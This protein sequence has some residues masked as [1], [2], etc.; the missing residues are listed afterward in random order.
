[1]YVE[2][3]TLATKCAP[4]TPQFLH[5][6]GHQDQKAN[7]PLTIWEQYN[8]NCNERAKGYTRSVTQSS[9]KLG[10]PAIP[11]AQPHLQI[12]GKIV[13]RNLITALRD[14]TSV[15]PYLQY[16]KKKRQWTATDI[17]H[18]H[19]T[20]LNASLSK[21]KLED[22]R[23]L[24]LFINDK[25]PLCASKAHPHIGSP[26]CPSCQRKPETPCHF[27]ECNHR[28]WNKLFETLRHDLSDITQRFQ[29]HPC[30]FTAIWLGL[31][32]TRQNAAYPDITTEII[33][34]LILPIQIQTSLG[35]KQLYYGHVA[36]AWASAI[37]EIHPT[38]PVNGKQIL[39]QMITAIWTHTMAA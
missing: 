17:R 28:E 32:T 36:T 23:Q 31:S 24:I 9:T 25:L 10:N 35:W 26:L 34:S 20:V 8:I 18:V 13:C 21:F 37:D 1:V 38:L 15:P 33:P 30:I 39:I 14:A 6:K 4:L 29:L 22:Q 11:T 12:A 27:L 7:R 3:S 19:W 16:L 5:V 2:L